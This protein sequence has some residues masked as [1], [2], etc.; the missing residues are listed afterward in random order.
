MRSRK[1]GDGDNADKQL[2]ASLLHC[3][4][5]L[6]RL[7]DMLWLLRKLFYGAAAA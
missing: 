1:I 5:T 7:G 2:R 4:A 6:L 3:I